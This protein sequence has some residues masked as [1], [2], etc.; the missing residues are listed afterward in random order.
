MSVLNQ[1]KYSLEWQDYCC[2]I[3]LLFF[4][5]YYY[6]LFSAFTQLPSEFYG[7]DH[8]AH[9]GSALRIYDTYNP[10]ISSH[11]LGELQHY[12]WL[13]PF[14]IAL[15]AKITGLE[16]FR[17]AILFPVL[18]IFFTLCITYIFG[19]YYFQNKTFALIL[20]LT[21]AVQLVPNF[22]PSEFAKQV[23]MPLIAFF[24]LLLYDDTALT[25]KRQ[26]IAGLIYGIAGLQHMVTF[27]LTTVLFFTILF[28]KWVQQKQAGVGFKEL[29]KKYI[30]VLFLGWLFAGLFWVP[31]LVKY[32]GKT[33][34][35]WQAYTAESLY[36]SAKAVTGYFL[37]IFEPYQN[38]I[39]FTASMFLFLL[40]LYFGIKKTDKKIFAPLLLFLAALVGIIHPYIT[41]PLLG[42]T[43]GYYRFPITFVFVQHLFIVLGLYYLWTEV[44]QKL[45]KRMQLSRLLRFGITLFAVLLLFL[46]IKSSFI[47]LIDDYKASERYRYAI[48][49][50]T[51]IES[52]STRIEAYQEL[53]SFIKMQQ[54][55]EEEDVTLVAHPDIGFLFSALTGK[56]VLL[57][58]ITHANPF[59]DHNKRAADTAILL[60][61]NDTQKAKE[62]VE[63]YQV[64]YFFSEMGNI[65]YRL[66]CSRKW[67]QTKSGSAV[68]KTILAYWCL[69]TDPIYKEYLEEYGIE[70][71]TAFVRLAAGDSDVPLTEVLVIKP[72]R[73]TLPT[74]DI[75][76][77]KDENGTV[78]LK[79]YE[80]VEWSENSVE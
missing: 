32:H 9:Y 59:V 21:W 8:Y 79:L 13:V 46:W 51:D 18:I 50:S 25:R 24:I 80:I 56:N 14:L 67:N 68:D 57:S 3:A 74:K 69:Q 71:T 29:S 53:R 28:L 10:F 39:L 77:Y 37:G 27:F 35:E 64:K 4:T 63:Q 30:L 78:I 31:L 44:L 58:R 48:G 11:Y 52:Y 61:G 12:P 38:S 5:I 72:E 1:R 42:M 16:M 6:L 73:I 36:P 54:L 7:G 62:L 43:L 23:M 41:L 2:G 20:A 66:Y 40:A 45:F 34:N 70:T 33:V 49:N 65:E 60:Y 76:A 75:Y 47:F 17:A 26:I 15:F 19:K 22:H 55:L